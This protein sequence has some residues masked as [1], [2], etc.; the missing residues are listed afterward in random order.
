LFPSVPIALLVCAT[1]L[2]EG[3][4]LGSG[5]RLTVTGRRIRA[6]AT[7]ALSELACTSKH[8]DGVSR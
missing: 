8:G 3:F 5:H 1:E 4:A 2:R 6:L 7:S